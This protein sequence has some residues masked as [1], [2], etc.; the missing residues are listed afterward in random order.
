MSLL[1]RL[2]VPLAGET[3]L[4]VHYFMA[5]L[6]EYKRGAAG[7]TLDAIGDGFGLDAT[8][9]SHLQEFLTNLDT[10]VIDRSKIH[11]V[12]LLGEGLF[13]A[14]NKCKTELGLTSG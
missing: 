3:K 11:D 13:Y 9:R 2:T 4:P 14:K 1:T 12:L 10:D 5:A 7:V 6:A 8:E